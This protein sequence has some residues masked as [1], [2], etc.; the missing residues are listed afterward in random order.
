MKKNR[1]LSLFLIAIILFAALGAFAKIMTSLD[2][3]EHMYI[4]ASV[5]FSQG[6]LLYKDFA[7]L[8]TPYLPLLYGSF[9]KLFGISSYYLLIGKLFSFL[10]LIISTL[11]LFFFA[12]R[13]FGNIE[14]SLC[15]AALFLLNMTIVNPATEVSNY[16]MPVAL[17]LLGTYIFIISINDNKMKTFPIA[18]SG[19][20]IAI[21][22]GTKLTYATIVFPFFAVILLYPLINERSWFS[23]KAGIVRALFPFVVGI[24]I[25]ILPVFFYFL[26]DPESFVFNNLGYHS[27]NT[28]WRQLTGYPENMSVFSKLSYARNIF[29]N[30]DN[31]IVMIGIL[32][33]VAFTTHSLRTISQLPIGGLLAFILFLVATLTAL[34]PTPS[35]FQYYAVP[36]SFLFLF[37]VYSYSSC[38]E[39]TSTLHQKL[40]VILVLVTSLYSGPVFVKNI[41]DLAHR[42]KWTGIWTHDVSINIK[43]AVL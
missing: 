4:A 31:L 23:I 8:Q 5:L 37:L 12:R 38:A 14:R 21:A 22:V 32:F 28:Q 33:G 2:H 27:V 30:A 13:I 18:L 40:L 26:Q 19:L 20:L 15:V 34:A 43:N 36:V 35:F 16:I 24:F 1:L 6:K 41:S 42:D 9:Y 25:G 11:T 29:L 3:N 39:E 10:F 7:Y 17:S